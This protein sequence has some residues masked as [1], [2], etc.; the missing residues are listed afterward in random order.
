MK[1]FS[2]IKSVTKIK[3]IIKRLQLLKFEE[4]IYYFWNKFQDFI[5]IKM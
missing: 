2:F 5:L 4:K 1:I 3:K